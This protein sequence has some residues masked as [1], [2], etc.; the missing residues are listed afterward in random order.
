MDV[1]ERAREHRASRIGGDE[2]LDAGDAALETAAEVAPPGELHDMDR[3]RR[4]RDGRLPQRERLL[5]Q[6]GGALEVAESQLE[7]RLRAANLPSLR[8]LPEPLRQL[9]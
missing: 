4:V 3:D 7:Q 5:A 1:D 9:V 6:L 2:P 8:R